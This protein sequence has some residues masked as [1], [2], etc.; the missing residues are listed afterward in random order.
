M[1]GVVPRSE[2]YWWREELIV[3]NI[4]GE[5]LVCG[6]DSRSMTGRNTRLQPMEDTKQWLAVPMCCYTT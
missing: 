6:A 1:E 2:G 4:R 3:R 5:E